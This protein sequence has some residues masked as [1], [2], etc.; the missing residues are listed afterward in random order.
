MKIKTILAALL[1]SY[2]AAAAPFGW[3]DPLD[4]VGT[5][6]EA[7][8]SKRQPVLRVIHEDG[9][10]G[11][12]FYDDAE[13]LKGP[14]ILPKA[15]LLTLDATLASIKELPVGWEAVRKSPKEKWLRAKVAQ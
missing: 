9:H 5:T 12:Q 11:W 1:G 7:V 15:Q 14:V 3:D 13:P 10:G 2:S 4:P 8:A 6:T